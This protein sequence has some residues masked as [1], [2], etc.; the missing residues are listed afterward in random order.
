MDVPKFYTYVAEI[1]SGM[2]CDEVMC[3]LPKIMEPLDRSP[4]VSTVIADM[5]HLA[6]GE[7]G[8]DKIGVMFRTAGLDWHIF[9]NETTK[10]DDFIKRNKLEF[11]LTGGVPKV[12]DS[13]VNLINLEKELHDLVSQPNLN[14]EDVFSL[15]ETSVDKRTASS[16]EFVNMV[17]RTIAGV[18]VKSES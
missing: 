7:H 11:T 1:L 9:L 6:S 17:V 13:C 8:H 14:K 3:N 10:L 4:E 12:P 16:K 15:L 5:L 2:L 18:A